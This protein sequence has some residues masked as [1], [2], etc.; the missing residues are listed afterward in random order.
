[1]FSSKFRCNDVI[2][3]DNDS[4]TSLQTS[5]HIS[6]PVCTEHSN[7]AR[8]SCSFLHGTICYAPICSLCLSNRQHAMAKLPN[9]NMLSNLSCYLCNH[10]FEAEASKLY[11][12]LEMCNYVY[13]KSVLP[14]NE[15]SAVDSMDTKPSS[16]I[17][18]Q[19]LTTLSI[20]ESEDILSTNDFQMSS[21]I[22]EALSSGNLIPDSLPNLEGNKKNRLKN[23]MISF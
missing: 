8:F 18:N 11:S 21:L 7:P 9:G 5:D 12:G 1:M 22:E 17:N 20:A 3:I 23:V 6:I 16:S 2:T 10:H 19:T 15:I 4:K 14:Y 13:E